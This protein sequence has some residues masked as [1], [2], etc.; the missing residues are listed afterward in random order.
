MPAAP[1]AARFSLHAAID[2]IPAADWDALAPGQPFL[3]HAF[4]SLL[5]ATGCVSREAGWV[6]AHAALWEEG[7][8]EGDHAPRLLAAMPLYLKHHSY[9]EFVFDWAWADAYHRNG[10][11]Y[12]PK[13]LA[14]VP[15]SPIPGPRLLGRDDAARRTL[16]AAVQDA[17]AQ[18]GLS[19][20]H[21]LFADEDECRWGEA[22]GFMRR[23]SVQ[24]H[25][26][27]RGWRDFDDFLS[28][29][30][31]DKR[32]KIRQERRRVA[33]AGVSLRV[34]EGPAI[35]EVDWLFFERC[36]AHTYALHHSTP[37]LN[38]EFFLRLGR[39]M[40]RHC[41]MLVASRDG[42]DIGASLLLRDDEVLYGRYWGALEQVS[43]LHFEACYYAPIAYAIAQGL[44]RFEGGAQGEHK[45]SR[46]LEPVVTHSLHWLADARFQ[47]AV[48][49]Y[50]QRESGGMAE[51]VDELE[52][53]SPFKLP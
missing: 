49:R 25:W 18:S 21:I 22:A 3:R 4:L 26:H 34:L 12:Y 14:A 39:E 51:Y 36:Y 16:L 17:A 53:R 27:N 5:E 33:D 35:R 48:A 32:K 52:R 1:S 38:R 11:D 50:L 8:E 41:V 7:E 24:F 30:S 43:C 31:H 13:W 37:Y 20:L 15:F 46:G 44:Q 28:A 42:N 2:E 29:M 45:L 47:D 19:S 23:E 40:P 9:G 6:P 10:L